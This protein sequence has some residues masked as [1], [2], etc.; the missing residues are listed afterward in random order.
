MHNMKLDPA[1]FEMIKS[2]KKTIELRVYDEKRQRIKVGDEITFTNVANGEVLN[3][4]VKKLH[5][6]ATFDELYK[7][8]PL[9]KCGYTAE[10]IDSAT[11][12]D[13]ERYYSVE[14]QRE[15]GVVGIELCRPKK[16]QTK[17]LFL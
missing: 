6:F 16:L 10:N 1:P 7:S 8:L 13:M 11:P 2:G 12:A 14:E 17:M 15:Y 5:C 4:T 3:V 9:L